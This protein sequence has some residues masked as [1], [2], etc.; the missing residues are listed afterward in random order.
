[1]FCTSLFVDLS[2]HVRRENFKHVKKACIGNDGLKQALLNSFKHEHGL[3]FKLIESLELNAQNKGF[4]AK[5]LKLIRNSR[6]LSHTHSYFMYM[7]YSN[8]NGNGPKNS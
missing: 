6:I 5:D 4:N 3:Y 7:W 8:Y 2:L 1:M